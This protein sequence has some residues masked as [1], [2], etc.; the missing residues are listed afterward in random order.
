MKPIAI[1]LTSMLVFVCGATSVVAHHSAAA[2]DFRRRVEIEGIVTSIRVV[3]PHTRI[4]LQVTDDQGTREIE[5]EGHS[6]NNFYRAGWRP[7][8][9]RPGD[10]ITV[11]IAPP[12]DGGDG[13]YITAFV[14]ADGEQIGF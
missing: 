9:V 12:R 7:D 11:T 14:T 3:N 2:F 8:K 1:V 4:F 13:G 5:F 10:T 6:R